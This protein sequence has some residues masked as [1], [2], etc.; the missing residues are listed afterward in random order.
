MMGSPKVGGT[1]LII[2]SILLLVG[3]ILHPEFEVEDID[4]LAR[5][6]TDNIIAQ[7]ASH[8][9]FILS[10]TF[11]MLGFLTLYGVLAQKDERIY[12]LPALLS[13][14]LF[15]V[16]LIVPS[17]MDGFLTPI[18]A[19][20]YLAAS[21]EAKE[22]AAMILDYNIL[23]LLTLTAAS[24]LALAVSVTLLSASLVKAKLY[25]KWFA[26]VGVA[27][28][29]VGVLGYIGG[30][31]GPYWLSPVVWLYFFIFIIWFLVLGIFLYRG[32]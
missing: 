12:S 23:L 17:L 22:S 16:L 9:M 30:I 1:A 14:G 24:M 27:L 32:R 31:F 20:N 10:S 19:Q 6:I 21:A 11:L 4:A 15:T 28:G 25:N 26:W 2:G 18:L 3:G 5:S 8:T 13:L 7:Y 29:L